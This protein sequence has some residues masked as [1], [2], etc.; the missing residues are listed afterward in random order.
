MS[1][2]ITQC[3]CPHEHCIVA[4]AWEG[5]ES[6]KEQQ[7]REFKDGMQKV[8]DSRALNPWCG[9]CLSR[10]FHYSTHRT[11]WKT[12]EEA[13]PH[14]YE[15]EVRQLATGVI[16]GELNEQKRRSSN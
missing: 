7:E 8:F 6:E 4:V 13:K 5:E 15:S 10:E 12:V 16:L 9:L 1:V 11:V 14:L 3:K 2:Y